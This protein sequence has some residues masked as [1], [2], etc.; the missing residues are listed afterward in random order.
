MDTWE[1]TWPGR[2]PGAGSLGQRI[3]ALRADRGWT[4]QQLADRLGI[5]RVAV[6]HLETDLNIPGER[7]VA[8]LAGLFR[9]EPHDLVAATSYP[10]AKSDRLPAVVA[11]WTEVEHQLELL[12][13]DLWWLDGADGA[14]PVA[15][16]R[17]VAVVLDGWTSLLGKLDAVVVD[18]AERASLA[19]ARR[20]ISARRRAGSG[21]DDLDGPR[22]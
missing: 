11:R 15:D 3:S 16:E 5:S 13:R 8:L 22:T 19:S 21:D 1:P 4:Q 2:P 14:G 17:T 18:P 20:A 6:S 12:R 10:V 9:M 7:T